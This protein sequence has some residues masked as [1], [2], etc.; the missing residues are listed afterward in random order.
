MRSDVQY[1]R[2]GRSRR[3]RHDE[4]YRSLKAH[5]VNCCL[6][7]GQRLSITRLSQDFRSSNTPVREAL[8]RLETE[9]LIIVDADGGFMV[10]ELS[11]AEMRQLLEFLRLLLIACVTGAV[12]DFRGHQTAWPVALMSQ[13]R[14]RA[15]RILQVQAEETSVSIG[16]HRVAFP[17]NNGWRE[18][19]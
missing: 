5:L 15:S 9:R 11:L 13:S 7:P 4:I 14:F 19:G 3:P 17:L 16:G 18:Q 6:R 12:G 2:A 1:C 8:I 10:R